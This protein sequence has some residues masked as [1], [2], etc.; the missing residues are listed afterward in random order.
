[1]EITQI[2]ALLEELCQKVGGDWLLTGGS[3][4]QLE[5]NG[6]RATEDI[7]VVLVRHSQVSDVIA[8]DRLFKAAIGLGLS[9]ENVN[10]AA[11]FFVQQIQNWENHLIEIKSGPVG[12]VF[13][14]DLTLFVALKLKRGTEIDLEDI[15]DAVQF[16]HGKNDRINETELKAMLNAEQFKKLEAHRSR[17]GL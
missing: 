4:V 3:L 8:Q 9:P 12:R 10:S 13:R 16:C 14:P 2:S 11:R 15:R 5:F 1:M 6:Q 7:D 17:L